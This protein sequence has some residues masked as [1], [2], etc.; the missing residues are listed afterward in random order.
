MIEALED[1]ETSSA[2]MW[3]L[4]KIMTSRLRVDCYLTA[5]AF[6]TLMVMPCPEVS[7][8]SINVWGSVAPYKPKTDTSETGNSLTSNLR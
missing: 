3:I 1:L 6:Q 4:Q 7:L 2:E 5:L 8:T